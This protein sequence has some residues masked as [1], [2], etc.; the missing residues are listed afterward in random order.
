MSAREKTMGTSIPASENK[1]AH[2]Q[3]HCQN[4]RGNHDQ[5]EYKR[6]TTF[7]T[8]AQFRSKGM[9]FPSKDPGFDSTTHTR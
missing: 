8:L 7:H 9:T 2:T 5:K 4:K 1:V 6:K 3:K